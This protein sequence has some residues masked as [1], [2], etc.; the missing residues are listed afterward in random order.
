MCLGPTEAGGPAI[1]LHRGKGTIDA[2]F[3]ERTFQLREVA[4]HD[5]LHIGVQHGRVA[6]LILAPFAGYLVRCG[7][8]YV[9]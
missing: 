4:L 2:E 7:D 1:R 3:A 9:R 8:G 5:G 6:A